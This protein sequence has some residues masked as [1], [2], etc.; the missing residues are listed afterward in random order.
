MELEISQYLMIVGFVSLVSHAACR[1]YVICTLCTGIGCATVYVGQLV[2]QAML[3]GKH[4]NLGFAGVPV[5]MHSAMSL[6][7]SA[8][9]GLPFAYLRRQKPP[10]VNPKPLNPSSPS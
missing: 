1:E 2:C 10:S 4:V 5:M 6:P 9:V 7:I 3:E 8:I